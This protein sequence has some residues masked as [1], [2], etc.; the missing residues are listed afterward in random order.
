MNQ[1]FQSGIFPDKLNK[2]RVI[3]L[4][5]EGNPKISSNYRPISLLPAFSKIID[6]LMHRRLYRFLEVHR[7]LY[8][9]KFGFQENHSVDYALVSLTEAVR[10]TLDNKRFLCRLFIELQKTFDM[11]NHAIL[12]SK[13][14][15]YGVRGCA[16]EWSR[17]YLSDKSQ[18]DSL[19]RSNSKFLSVTNVVP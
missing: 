16:L 8:S 14:E 15:H 10:N 6:K 12:L 2:G 3:S 17:P 13:L 18:Y 19:N 4:F 9:L 5:Q 11:V 7:V 1:S